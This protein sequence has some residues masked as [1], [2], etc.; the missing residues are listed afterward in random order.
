MSNTKKPTEAELRKLA[1][2][3]VWGSTGK[4][5]EPLELVLDLTGGQKLARKN[6]LR[7]AAT[8]ADGLGEA[9]KRDDART[10]PSKHGRDR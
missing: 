5:F 6:K 3:R 7:G 4:Q 1:H 10:E 2:E 9:Q 8:T